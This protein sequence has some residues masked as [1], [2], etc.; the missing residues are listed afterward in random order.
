MKLELN[1]NQKRRIK[2]IF[3]TIFI[4]IFIYIFNLYTPLYADDYS[5]SVSFLT[6]QRI[7]S[8]YDIFQSQIEHYKMI[9]GR[10]I[11][12]FLAQLFLYMGKPIF[13][14]INSCIFTILIYLIYFHS[15]GTFKNIKISWFLLINCILWVLTPAF[16]QSFLWITG[17]CNYMYGIF[18]I[19]VFLIPY[20]KVLSNAYTRKENNLIIKIIQAIT[21]L[22]LGIIAGWTNENTGVALI[23]MILLF[24]INYKIEN[25]EFS[26][27]MFTGL[28]GSL[29]GFCMILFSPGQATRLSNSGGFGNIV[30][31]FKRFCFISFDFFSYLTPIL[32]LLGFY[33]IFYLV[34]F[35]KK[36]FEDFG[37]FFIYFLGSVVSV[38]C[39]IVA[40]TFPDRVWSGCI[41]IFVIAV[42]NIY[43][44]IDWNYTNFTKYFNICLVIICILNF[45]SNYM[46]A[47]FE[48]KYVKSQND[49]R[50]NYILEE[51]EKGNL[52]VSIKPILSHSKYSCFNYYGDLN[53]D[54]NNW[55]N[56]AIARYYGLN[57]VSMKKE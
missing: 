11:A 53:K 19:L 37:D 45:G 56:T 9:N 36:L 7:T 28:I 32:I 3:F 24:L 47:F 51:K 23:F 42:G 8:I 27:W 4:F 26:I 14:I 18:I 50:V 43:S 15:Y 22:L 2:I 13:N 57:T 30:T 40:P 33:L 38:Y 48:L 55:P 5:Y 17:S 35:N 31:I 6:K 46:N 34:Y 25:K 20:R 54:K 29:I 10:S 16:G 44:L 39:M 49:L 52:D 1:L 12:H 41:I 21:C